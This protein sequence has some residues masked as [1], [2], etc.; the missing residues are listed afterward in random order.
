[1]A[2]VLVVE[3]CP[4]TAETLTILL[5]H[6]G[7]ETCLAHSGTE[8]VQAAYMFEPD[9]AILDIGL[10]ELDGFAVAAEMR[11]QRGRKL[12]LVALTGYATEDYRQ[13]SYRAGFDHYLIKPVTPDTLKVLLAG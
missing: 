6:W 11:R 5:R 8:A 10:P 7:H 9:V 13:R 2:R 4:D 12:L 1:M 3:D